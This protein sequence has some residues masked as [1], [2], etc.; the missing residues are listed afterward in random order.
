ML[1]NGATSQVLYLSLDHLTG[2]A[3][4]SRV[5]PTTGILAVQS[6]EGSGKVLKGGKSVEAAS[7]LTDLEAA[8]TGHGCRGK[9]L[10][11]VCLSRP[12]LF[13]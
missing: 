3:E 2:S 4:N 7:H 11:T 9:A 13:W 12:G 1:K 5:S 10:I 8:A 6:P